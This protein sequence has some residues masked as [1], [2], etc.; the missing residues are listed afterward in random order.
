MQS[1]MN[2]ALA[3]ELYF[4]GFDLPGYA[5]F[6]DFTIRDLWYHKPVASIKS[7]YH[8]ARSKELARL[9]VE[10]EVGHPLS[11]FLEFKS[12]EDFK[13][14][15]YGACLLDQSGKQLP[16]KNIFVLFIINN[17]VTLIIVYCV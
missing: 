15:P 8:L 14:F 16:L 11:T 3:D 2:D 6:S 12:G 10:F 4:P 17:S 9:R 7:Q 13:I 1:F 5:T